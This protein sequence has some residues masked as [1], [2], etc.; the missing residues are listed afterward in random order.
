MTTESLIGITSGII[1]IIGAAVSAFIFFYDRFKQLP[2]TDLMNQL[3]DTKLSTKDHQKILKKMNRQLRV[4]GVHIKSEYIQ[5]FVL[6]DRGKESVFMDM[7]VQ[8][9]IEPTKEICQKFLGADS[10]KAREYFH[11]S[12]HQ[13][14][15]L[16][17]EIQKQEPKV[18]N[19]IPHSGQIVYMSEL[20]KERFPET[21]DNLIKILE[22]HSVNYAFLKGTNDIWCRDYMPVQTPSGKLIQFKYDPSYLKGNPQWEASRSDVKK[23]DDLNNIKAE[24]SDIN[25]DGGNVLIRDDR[26]IL[27]DRIF[28]E[29]PNYDKEA[30]VKE[31]S[32]LLECEIIIIPALKSKE[33]DFTGHA[34]GM[35]RFVDRNTIVGNNR[36]QEYKY[37][38]VG[39]KNVLDTYHLS[40]IDIPC[41]I[42]KKDPK[43]PDSAIGVYVN[44]LEVNN[45]I[46]VPEFGVKEDREAVA[47]LQK[48]FPNK[49]IE[50]IN[51]NDVALEGG[52][53]N[54][55]TWVLTPNTQKR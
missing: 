36:S 23:V 44:Y 41:I 33:E 24:F 16:K 37:W 21:C 11:S 51:Y 4:F 13:S 3:V 19:S 20:L 43:H 28:S 26:A 15:S 6:K 50:T 54:C 9:N 40:Y 14:P 42:G 52:L 22:K 25:L 30:L 46:V 34:D 49:Q 1:G 38:Q 35:V 45:L 17:E 31:L 27:S 53:L 18:T 29:N 10:R 8:N 12:E 39:M 48:A 2:L 32:Q 7:C 47:I 55:T 5:K